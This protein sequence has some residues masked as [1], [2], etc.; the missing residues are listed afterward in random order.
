MLSLQRYV[1]L[2]ILGGEVFYVLCILYGQSLSGTAAEL[3][4]ALFELLPGFTWGTS[5]GLIL[6]A[7]NVF[8][9]SL[10]AGT[11]IAWMHN[12]SLLKKK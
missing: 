2:C 9:I 5:T 8:V 10:I 1:L 7:I 11:Y 3:H 12:Y 6:G 4:H